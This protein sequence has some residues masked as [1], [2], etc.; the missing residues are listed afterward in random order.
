MRTRAALVLLLA[1]GSSAASPPPLR[2]AVSEEP[3]VLGRQ[4]ATALTLAL[5]PGSAGMAAAPLLG[6]NVGEVEPAAQVES[7]VY[8]AGMRLPEARFPHFLQVIAAREMG[9]HL[10]VGVLRVPLHA[11]AE[12]PVTG[13][14]RGE[15][16]VQLGEKRAGPY[17]VE[18]LQTVSLPVLIP[19][20]LEEVALHFKAD[21]GT[22]VRKVALGSPPYN[23][24]A[25]V[26]VPRGR[27]Q[28]RRFSLVLSHSERTLR[29]EE[30]RVLAGPLLVTLEA[31]SADH[32]VYALETPET[33]GSGEHLL[34]VELTG[35]A[36]ASFERT[37]QVGP[38]APSEV[39]DPSPRSAEARRSA[40][41]LGP[42]AAA[43]SATFSRWSPRL[44]GWLCW[45]EERGWGGRLTGTY[46]E[47]EQSFLSD[48]LSAAGVASAAE[49]SLSLQ[50]LRRVE[51]GELGHLELGVGLLARSAQFTSSVTPA[52][53]TAR[54]LGVV[55]S[56]GILRR[57]GP[58]EA[59]MELAYGWSPHL[60]AGGFRLRGD[61]LELRAG[62]RLDLFRSGAETP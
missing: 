50:A 4:A 53:R 46:R 60:E 29:P 15:V 56:L 59:A 20:G 34:R 5:A 11:A 6:V 33:L 49:L 13:S 25:G 62:Y 16:F 14:E 55:A 48:P 10:E 41:T 52:P 35:D 22:T 18:K 57:W 28:S 2:L 30:L 17:P 39:A 26:V 8:R 43:G 54:A 23:R 32:L 58:G 38:D 44:G 12:L 24:L 19:P 40:L 42:F 9:G 36:H 51:V 7:A 61:A 47:A 1:C 21:T 37:I 3:L 27:A 31:Q 45:S